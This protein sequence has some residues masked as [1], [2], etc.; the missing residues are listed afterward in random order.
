MLPILHFWVVHL[1][2]ARQKNVNCVVETLQ[3]TGVL[4][5]KIIATQEDCVT[6]IEGCKVYGTLKFVRFY[7]EQSPNVPHTVCV[8]VLGYNMNEVVD[9]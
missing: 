6:V 4:C 7:L 2:A 5:Y 3:F 8:T 1:P 9:C